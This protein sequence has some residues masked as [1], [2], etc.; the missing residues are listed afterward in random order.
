MGLSVSLAFLAK[1][2]LLNLEKVKKVRVLFKI[3]NLP[4]KLKLAS[5]VFLKGI[6]WVSVINST[7]LRTK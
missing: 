4:V 7:V 3:I 6:P 2:H 1:V 5:Y